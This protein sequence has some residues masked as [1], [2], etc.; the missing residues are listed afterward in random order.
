MSDKLRFILSSS[1]KDRSGYAA[2]ASVADDG[3]GVGGVNSNPMRANNL[4]AG[5]NSRNRQPSASVLPL[6]C[7]RLFR[8]IVETNKIRD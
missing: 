2:A 5:S 1:G 8:G 6:D 7:H 4:V 3:G